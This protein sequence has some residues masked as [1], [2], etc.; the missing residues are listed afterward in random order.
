MPSTQPYLPDS[1]PAKLWEL[2]RRNR[3]FRRVV[4]R[5]RILRERCETG[6]PDER[7]ASLNTG[8]QILKCIQGNGN[9]FGSLAL[10]WLAPQPRFEVWEA[11]ADAED[12]AVGPIRY[13]RMGTGI[14]PDP[15]DA[16]W[17]WFE[18][19]PGPLGSVDSQANAAGRPLRWGPQITTTISKDQ[20]IKSSFPDGVTAWREWFATHTFT[21]D[22]PWSDAPPDFQSQWKWHWE[23]L[24]GTN[25]AAFETDFFQGWSLPGLIQRS[26]DTI[27]SAN[28]CIRD[29]AAD[30]DN[31]RKGHPEKVCP[32]VPT[33]SGNSFRG[34]PQFDLT[35]S[36]VEQTKRIQF[37]LTAGKRALVLPRLISKKDAHQVFRRLAS[38]LS[39]DLPRTRELL[40]T[41]SVWKV[42]LAIEQYRPPGSDG[43]S[44]AMG[45]FFLSRVKLRS[46]N[47]FGVS[48]KDRQEWFVDGKLKP[49]PSDSTPEDSAKYRLLE[50]AV[51]QIASEDRK[52]NR[53]FERWVQFVE[54][55]SFATFPRLDLNKLEQAP[56]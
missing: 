1:P 28:Q 13:E 4:E 48:N 18:R 15:K 2:L 22:T 20:R 27:K 46:L 16:T 10:Q 30:L 19:E 31:V 12:K 38:A 36:E 6:S 54:E 40:G 52:T 11:V 23:S 34:I 25:H 56:P 35:L 7:R 50:K 45:P 51:I 8:L 47:A 42:Y 24:T 26:G 37:Q 21:V 5:M 53:H 44:A 9:V 32:P 41:A 43:F 29:L 55:L 14:T 33:R 39:A 49:L 17:Q 3:Q